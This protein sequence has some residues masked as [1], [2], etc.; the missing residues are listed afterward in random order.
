MPFVVAHVTPR[1]FAEGLL[2]DEAA[3]RLSAGPRI[4]IVPSENKNV[5]RLLK[6]VSQH[7]NGTFALIGQLRCDDSHPAWNSVQTWTFKSKELEGEIEFK[8]P[9]ALVASA[10]PLVLLEK[11]LERL[12]E[13]A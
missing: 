8:I 11:F 1:E 13:I 3:A 2:A 12:R 6:S 7:A 4:I 9:Y 5:F 10:S